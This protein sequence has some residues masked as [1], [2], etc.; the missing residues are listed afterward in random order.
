[1][2]AGPD[3][4]ALDAAGNLCVSDPLDRRIQRISADGTIQTVAG[5]VTDRLSPAGGGSALSMSFSVQSLS[6]AADG[7][8]VA[9]AGSPKQLWRV[10]P[11][12]VIHLVPGESDPGA[13]VGSAR[14]LRSLLT[15]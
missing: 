7:T 5:P 15:A 12:Q 9:L 4:V 11:D 2:F 10:G 14:C 3:E 13:S 1:M 6:V 8:I